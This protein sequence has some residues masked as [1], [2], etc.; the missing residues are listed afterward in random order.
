M[1]LKA[2]D[3]AT[4]YLRDHK[5]DSHAIIADVFDMDEEHV[6]TFSD[7]YIFRISLDQVLLTSWDDIARWAMENQLVD[8]KNLPNYLD[9][10]WIDA[11]DDVK[12]EAISIIR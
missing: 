9:Y 10:V 8:G 7:N 5:E 2:I 1:F 11:L 4:E 6:Y 3:R 12:A